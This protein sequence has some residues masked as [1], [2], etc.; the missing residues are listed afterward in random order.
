[1]AAFGG[2][3]WPTAACGPTFAKSESTCGGGNTEN[4]RQT[5][6]LKYK[7][8]IG[9]FRAAALWQFGGYRENNA[10]NGAY[11]IQAGG[12]IPTWGKG[13]LSFDAIYS[14][15]R[16]STAIALG[17]GR[18]DANGVPIPPFLPQALTATLSDN[19]A[20][21]LLAKYSIQRLKLYAGYE[22]I[23]YMAPSDPQTDFTDI[24][25]D[26]LCQG[27]IGFNNTDINNTA[28]GRN[29]LG[30]RI[31]QVMWTGARYS[32]TDKLD[33]IAAG[34]KDLLCCS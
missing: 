2:G 29:G 28:Y 32:L 6:S 22:R 34:G 20:V 16:D 1:M 9:N 23:T 7:I 10:S 8:G 5:T 14:Y 31:L 26:F 13:L 25:L 33:V 24:S 15:V 3:L 4:C 30:N 12:D 11:Q 27:C 18:N 21:M 19:Y 17:P